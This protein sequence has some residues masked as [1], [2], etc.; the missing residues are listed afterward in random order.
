MFF[1]VVIATIFLTIIGMTGGFVLGERHRERVNAAQTG[2]TAD[3]IVAAA[4]GELCPAETRE[5]AAT[6]GFPEELRQV[7]KIQTAG[8]TTVWICQ[9]DQERLYYQGKTGGS[10]APIVQNKNGLFLPD[11]IRTGTDEYE[12]TAGNGTRFVVDRELLEIHFPDGR[13]VQA[14]RVIE[15]E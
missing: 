9:D 10:A 7:L 3:P 8:E 5:I 14:D 15:A 6:L 4:P 2:P 11:V 12:A 1:P 13:P